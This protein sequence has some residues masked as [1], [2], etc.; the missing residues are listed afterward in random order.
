MTPKTVIEEFT[1]NNYCSICWGVA[2]DVDAANAVE[3]ANGSYYHGITHSADNCGLSTNQVI[4]DFN[5][6]KIPDLM[7]ETK[8][9]GLGDLTCYIMNK[10]I[11]DVKVGDYIE[12][13]TRADTRVW[14]HQGKVEATYPGHPN[15]S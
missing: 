7:R 1:P 6:D 15:M 11:K 14:H 12:W 9:D 4:I 13:E 3:M 5:N 10:S 8:T 2:C